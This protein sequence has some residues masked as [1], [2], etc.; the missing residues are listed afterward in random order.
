[1]ASKI[2]IVSVLLRIRGTADDYFLSLKKTE[3]LYSLRIRLR[4]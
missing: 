4:G 1:M 2:G 3:I